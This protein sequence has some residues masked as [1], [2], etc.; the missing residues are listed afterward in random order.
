MQTSKL[1]IAIRDSLLIDVPVNRA[2]YN[3][4]PPIGISARCDFSDH[5]QVI[6]HADVARF[7]HDTVMPP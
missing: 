2:R 4:G 1:E 5:A 6:D 3:L 7:L